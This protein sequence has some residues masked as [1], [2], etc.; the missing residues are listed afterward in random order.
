[1]AN[2]FLLITTL[3][4]GCNKIK[5]TG[6]LPMWLGGATNN[7]LEFD[8]QIDNNVSMNPEL[9]IGEALNNSDNQMPSS[10]VA[11]GKVIMKDS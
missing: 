1:M 10:S 11:M 4:H 7:G 8:S 3:H 5:T 9:G 2:F 6:I